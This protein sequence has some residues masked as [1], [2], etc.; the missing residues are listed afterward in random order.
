[1]ADNDYA[2][3]PRYHLAVELIG[4]RWTGAIV[5]EMLNGTTRFGELRLAVPGLSD[6]LLS[7]RLKELENEGVVERHVIPDSPVR[8]EYR[9]T[10]MGQALAPV[11]DVISSWADVWVNPVVQDAPPQASAQPRTR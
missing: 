3:S 10:A 9:L 6:R 5:R 11:V 1:M 4:R 7:E 8:I 2:F